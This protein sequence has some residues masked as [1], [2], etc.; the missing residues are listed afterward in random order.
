MTPLTTVAEQL[1]YLAAIEDDDEYEREL[2]RVQREA[3]ARLHPA[4]P[5]FHWSPTE[6]RAGIIRRGL[7]VGRPHVTHGEDSS[8]WRA[9]Y[10]CFGPS[11]SLGWAL[12]GGMHWTPSGAWDLWQTAVGDL[13]EPYA[14]VES[15]DDPHGVYEV[16]TEHRVFKR[17]LWLVGSRWKP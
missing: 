2:R 12:S 11:P 14:R 16:R 4:T 17:H 3:C 5:L 8:G 10:L 9:H 15:P 1:D 7:V 6:R 13:T